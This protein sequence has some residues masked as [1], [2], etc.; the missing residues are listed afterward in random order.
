MTQAV[1]Q[2]PN[3]NTTNDTYN[4]NIASMLSLSEIAITLI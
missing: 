2:T 1:M 3:W 4:E